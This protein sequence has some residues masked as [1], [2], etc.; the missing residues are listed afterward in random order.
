MRSAIALRLLAAAALLFSH[1][2]SADDTDV[3]RLSRESGASPLRV[4]FALDIRQQ[5][6]KEVCG[7][8]SSLSCRTQLGEELY[9]ALDLFGFSQES[10]GSYSI[11]HSGDGRPDL[12]Q[13]LPSEPGQTLA[14]KY[15]HATRID[16]YEVM[17]AAF[18]VV[19]ERTSARLRALPSQRRVEVGLMVMHA[20]SCPGSGPTY[21]P[22]YQA[23]DPIGCSQGAY[24]LRGFT[25]ISSVS[26]LNG[27]LQALAALP[28]PGRVASWMTEPWVGHPYKIRDIYLELHRYLNGQPVFNGFLGNHDYDSQLAG[29]LYHSSQGQMINDVLL[30][31]SDD[32]SLRP[33]LS[34]DLKAFESS[35]LDLSTDQVRDAR[36]RKPLGVTESCPQVRLVHLLSGDPDS[37]KGETDRAI[38]KPP[39][40]SGLSLYLPRGKAG[41]LALVEFLSDRHRLTSVAGLEKSPA[42]ESYFFE[43]E[44]NGYGN[45]LA[46]AAGTDH[47]V[48]LPNPRN[49]VSTLEAVLSAPLDESR[50]M[51]A[52]STVVNEPGRTQISGD[53]FFPLFRPDSGARWAGNVKKLKFMRFG[54]GSDSI[55]MVVQA[56]LSSSPK[57]A[58]S[59]ADGLIRRDALTFWTDP[60]G[61]DVLAFDENLGEV[62]GTDGRSVTRGGAGQRIRGYLSDRPGLSNDELGARQLFTLDPTRVGE[63]LPLDA[64]LATLAPLA[65]LLDPSKTM[66]EQALL[67]ILRWIRGEDVFDS[68]GDGE[69]SDTRAWLLG[70]VLHSRPLAISYGAPRGSG[71]SQEN[72]DIRLFYGSNDGF[73]RVIRNTWPDGSESGEESWAFLPPGLLSM[74]PQLANNL[75]DTNRPYGM[76]GEPVAL[77]NDADGDGNIDPKDGDSVWVVVGQR[78]G[79]NGLFAFDVSN[80]DKP[81]FMWELSNKSFGFEQLALTFSTPRIAHLDLGKATPEPVLVFAGGYHGGRNGATWVGKDVSSATDTIGNAIYVVRPETGELVWRASGPGAEDTPS[82]VGSSDDVSELLHS[83][84]SPLSIIDSDNNGIDDRAY[85]GDS[86]GNVWRID[87]NESGD[88]AANMAGSITDYWQV[89]KLAALGGSGGSDR[90]FFHAPDVTLSKDAA[91][92]F[93]GIAILSGNRAAPLDMAVENYAY[94][95]KDR[96]E[97]EPADREGIMHSQ[98]QDVT[99]FCS[100]TKDVECLQPELLSGWKMELTY[101]GEK[102]LSTPVIA[103]GKLFFTSYVPA[104]Q[105]QIAQCEYSV[106]STRLY[107]IELLDASPAQTPM[108]R[109]RLA[110]DEQAVRH[111]ELGQGLLGDVVPFGPGLPIPGVVSKT[112]S[113]FPLEGASIQRTYWREHGVDEL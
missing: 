38:A 68:D 49:L 55:E 95:I 110:S 30:T 80:P 29:N 60:S 16:Y 112:S 9:S 2:S 93:V 67:R 100:K 84:P 78:R 36:Y 111:R 39:S 15:W 11:V 58:L 3:Y 108:G 102:G 7:D 13:P 4:M 76:D 61:F 91:S 32:T 101:L 44:T 82:P 66:D 27:W 89:S 109:L 6:I 87:F 81:K 37:S 86:G 98:L 19:L 53:L 25:D 1:L 12:S 26:G 34:P 57:P 52:A 64:N 5:G 51:L 83:I 14:S 94:F 113:L 72:P 31:S 63:L 73:F 107:A 97:G 71:Y 47:R 35:S 45:Q 8:A 88:R 79:G 103:D 21:L 18:R 65:T 28:D 33:L 59:D 70:D 96:R 43:I 62:S 77:I 99:Q 92:E 40:Q 42:I 85:V 75:L 105:N 90:R 46:K 41:D 10:D 54:E 69:T 106:G 104:Q 48:L 24:V 50:A 23:D 22:D 74:Q 20:D 17:R 56:P